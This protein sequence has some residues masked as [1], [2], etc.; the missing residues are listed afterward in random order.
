LNFYIYLFNLSKNSSEI[1]VKNQK[2]YKLRKT[3]RMEEETKADQ[4]C[5]PVFVRRKADLAGQRKLK[6][7][8]T[9]RRKAIHLHHRN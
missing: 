3:R 9:K 1:T 4:R 6:P 5:Q 7:K 8:S 2:A